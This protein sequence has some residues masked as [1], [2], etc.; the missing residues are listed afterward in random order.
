M[1]TSYKFSYPCKTISN[2]YDNF[3]GV[4]MYDEIK[5]IAYRKREVNKIDK[6]L[7]E[8]FQLFQITYSLPI[9]SSWESYKSVYC[10]IVGTEFSNEYNEVISKIQHDFFDGVYHF[11]KMNKTNLKEAF[12]VYLFI[13]NYM[14][15]YIGYSILLP[16]NLSD[17]C[18]SILDR[19]IGG[20]FLKGWFSMLYKVKK[21]DLKGQIIEK[22]A[23]DRQILLMNTI[24]EVYL[25]GSVFKEEYYDFSDID[26]IIKF[27]ENMSLEEVIKTKQIYSKYNKDNFDRDTD[28]VDYYDYVQIHDI[29]KT[30]RLI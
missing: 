10:L 5:A 4:H 26:I 6:V 25:F 22:Y 28:I 20:Y 3:Y 30:F 21:H 29:N 14:S 18:N 12:M 17:E 7:F 2:Y 13:Q 9:D 1:D 8:Y 23:K 16:A 11:V 19:K 15:K 27:K 24:E